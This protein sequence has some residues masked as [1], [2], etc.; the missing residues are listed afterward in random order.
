VS[1]VRTVICEKCGAPYKGELNDN[2]EFIQLTKC[3][4]KD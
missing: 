4:C 1:I 3:K 2:A